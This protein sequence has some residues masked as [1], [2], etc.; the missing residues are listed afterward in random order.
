MSHCDEGTIRSVFMAQVDNMRYS[1]AEWS[2]R[3][4]NL[5]R[6]KPGGLHFVCSHWKLGNTSL[7]FIAMQYSWSFTKFRTLLDRAGI[8]RQ[9]F[10]EDQ[11]ASF[12]DGWT[13]ERL[14]KVFDE[15]VYRRAIVQFSCDVCNIYVLRPQ[16]GEQP[17]IGRLQRIKEGLDPDGAL[18]EDELRDQVQWEKFWILRK[19]CL[20]SDC[21]SKGLIARPQDYWRNME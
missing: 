5:L 3:D 4:F 13:I 9:T 18:N 6:E 21:Q 14:S 15:P 12:D 11:I 20:C 2:I 7:I 1:S 19:V 8:D 10:L 16:C 17:W